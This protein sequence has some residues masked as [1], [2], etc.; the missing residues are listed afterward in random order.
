MRFIRTLFVIAAVSACMSK[1]TSSDTAT[2]ATPPAAAGPT[3]AGAPSV[4]TESA[5]A[6]EVNPPG[7]IPDTQAFVKYASTG[8]GYSLDVPEGWARTETGPNVK[9]VDKLDGVAV[10]VATGA[11]A[12]TAASARSAQVKQIEA[13]GRAVKI[14][15][16]AD[17]TLPSGKAV[18]IK[19]TSNSEPSAVTQKQVRLENEAY[20][21]FSNGKLATLTLWA[22][23]GA[24]NVD[25]WN[26]M[27][28]S[29]RWQ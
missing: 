21:Y 29:L 18:M 5:V 19:Y 4:D 24:D 1:G 3:R 16:V 9:F 27:S 23:Q 14:T 26:R 25:Q 22:P 13:S 20:L 15:E 17:V 6:S 7:D 10:D 11:T 28:K 8:G 2:P 12:P